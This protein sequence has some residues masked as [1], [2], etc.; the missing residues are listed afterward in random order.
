[1]SASKQTIVVVGAGMGGVETA[2]SLVNHLGEDAKIVLVSEH[3]ELALR[4]FFIYPPFSGMF[5][6]RART[7]LPLRKAAARRGIE[8]QEWRV[9]GID[10]DRREIR[11]DGH[12]QGFDHLVIATGAGMR[13]EEVPGLR[14]HANTI[15][16]FEDAL[17]LH[18]AVEQMVARAK[19][20]E[21]QRV[22]FNVAQGNK[23]AGPLYEM[24]F[25]LET[26]LRRHA[27]RDH[28]EIVWT[29][30]EGSFIQAFGP[31]LHDAATKEFAERGI[32]AHTG[33]Q[34]RSVEPKVATFADGAAIDFDWMIGF[35]PYVAN[36]RFEGLP[37]DDR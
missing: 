1:M 32:E 13:P 19:R 34:L 8:F 17:R 4:P 24:V 14:E 2:A 7:H 29:T 28:V 33:F 15:W 16:G 27:V 6:N 30:T 18:T 31:K 37:M 3:S 35:P 9:E 26:Y 5:R 23:C 36:T 22:L 21:N 10:L 12:A 25:M 20:G 11:A